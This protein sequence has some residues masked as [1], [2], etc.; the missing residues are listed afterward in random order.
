MDEQFISLFKGCDSIG[1]LGGSSEKHFTQEA[2]PFY[3]NVPFEETKSRR[4]ERLKHEE[5]RKKATILFDPMS[6]VTTVE[7]KAFQMKIKEMRSHF[8]PNPP[9]P[10]KRE[11]NHDRINDGKHHKNDENRQREPNLKGY[12]TEYDLKLF[13]E[14]QAV[15]SE[16]I[17]NDLLKWPP[18]KGTK[19]ERFYFRITNY[20]AIITC[21]ELDGF[22]ISDILQWADII[23]KFG[24]SHHIQK[25]WHDSLNYIYVNF[26]C[27]IKNLRSL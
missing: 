21:F 15:A 18:E 1:H 19:Y 14:A 10:I 25:M 12:V 17:E 20:E 24:I 9:L 7:Q 23:W 16:K 8:T 5:E 26:V 2:C 4:D 13:H 27:N 11:D 22:F 6:N 3:H